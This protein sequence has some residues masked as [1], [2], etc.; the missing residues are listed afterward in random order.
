MLNREQVLE[1][2][3]YEMPHFTIGNSLIFHLG[4]RRFLSLSCLATPNEML[5]MY[6]VNQDNTKKIDDSVILSNFDYD[7]YLTLEELTL[8]LSFFRRK[9][10]IKTDK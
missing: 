2:G 6:E 10:K 4:R 3:F 9:K 8:L 5:F 1:L 7:G